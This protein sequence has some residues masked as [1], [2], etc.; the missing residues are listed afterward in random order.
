MKILYFFLLVLFLL[1]DRPEITVAPA[2]VFI[3]S[4]P[5]QVKFNCSVNSFP[6]SNIVWM[7]NYRD[8]KV[9]MNKTSKQ[10][11]ETLL[12]SSIQME[13]NEDEH[14]NSYHYT[15]KKLRSKTK[16]TRKN[17][18]KYRIKWINRNP[19]NRVGANDD[20][21][22]SEDSKDDQNVVLNSTNTK[23]IIEDFTFNDSNK[24]SSLTINVESED[25]LGVYECFSNNTAGSKTQKFYVYGGKFG[26]YNSYL[27]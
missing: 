14:T 4:M 23:Y 2:K 18:N 25:D 27:V 16:K 10:L 6:D 26:K 20:D 11:R 1:L 24:L 12:S 21:S 19:R 13:E 8:L 22:A 7:K 17:L 9:A 3:G 15:N 5:T